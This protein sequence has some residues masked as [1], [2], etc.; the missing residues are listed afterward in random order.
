MNDIKLTIK[1]HLAKQ[2]AEK[3]NTEIM[4]WNNGNSLFENEVY[5][6][7]TLFEKHLLLINGYDNSQ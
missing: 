3:A 2:C 6:F 1:E 4:N 7:T 5:E